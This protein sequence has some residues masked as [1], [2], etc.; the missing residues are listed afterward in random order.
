VPQPILFRVVLSLAWLNLAFLA[1]DG[2]YNIVK[3][4]VNLFV[5]GAPT[6]I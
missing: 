2:L 6:Y 1:F 3:A 4:V 5:H